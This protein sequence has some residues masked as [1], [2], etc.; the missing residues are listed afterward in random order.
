MN[1][2]DL[3]PRIPIEVLTENETCHTLRVSRSTL[4]RLVE[5]GKLNRSAVSRGRR[6]FWIGEIRRLA[7]TPLEIVPRKVEVA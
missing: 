2:N 4:R 1:D 7:A 6:L 3:G 5:A